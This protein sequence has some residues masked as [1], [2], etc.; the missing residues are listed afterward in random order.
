MSLGSGN[1]NKVFLI[2]SISSVWSIKAGNGQ[3]AIGKKGKAI[4]DGQWDMGKNNK[5]VIG[6][7][8]N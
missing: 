2:R 4:G 8:S 6:S 5:W 3:E 1:C 7:L